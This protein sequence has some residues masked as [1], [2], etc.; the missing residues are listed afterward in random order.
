MGSAIPGCTKWD[1][2]KILLLVIVVA[3]A[4]LPSLSF[5][6]MMLYPNLESN[7]IART[8]QRIKSWHD[9]TMACPVVVVVVVVVV[10][11]LHLPDIGKNTLDHHS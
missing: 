10:V 7:A 5:A 6:A 2:G 3:V 9:A 1:F 11:L 4:L 8:S